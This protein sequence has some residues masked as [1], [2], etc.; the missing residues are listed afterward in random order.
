MIN[1][2]IHLIVFKNIE[3]IYPSF[4]NQEIHDNQ[5][6]NFIQPSVP[7]ELFNKYI[8]NNYLFFFIVYNR[9][10]ASTSTETEKEY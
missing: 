3:D 8:G 5:I 9:I 2:F 10:Y 1:L 7:M 4:V 6:Q